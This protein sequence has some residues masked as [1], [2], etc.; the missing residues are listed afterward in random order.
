V[1]GKEAKAAASALIAAEAG[2]P[3]ACEAKGEQE[4]RKRTWTR[5]E[6]AYSGSDS[7]ERRQQQ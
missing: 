7:G 6:P 1:D 5:R 4:E 2:S 3:G